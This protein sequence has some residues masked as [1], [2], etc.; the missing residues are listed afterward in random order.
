MIKQLN[1]LTI[2]ELTA[3]FKKDFYI[4]TVNQTLVVVDGLTSIIHP[5]NQ[6][7]NYEDGKVKEKDILNIKIFKNSSFNLSNDFCKTCPNNFLN[8]DNP[9]VAG[10][11]PCDWCQHN[12]FKVNC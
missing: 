2:Q 3:Y 9:I 7:V 10:D 6:I 11:S 5:L 12:P 1:E 4:D 8:S